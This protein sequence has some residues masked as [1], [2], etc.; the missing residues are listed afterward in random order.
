MVNLVNFGIYNVFF[1]DTRYSID[2]TGHG[3][4]SSAVLANFDNVL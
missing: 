3:T 1:L 4:I 2:Q